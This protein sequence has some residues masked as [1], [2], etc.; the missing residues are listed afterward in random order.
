MG[1]HLSGQYVRPIQEPSPLRR[2]TLAGGGFG[3]TTSLRFQPADIRVARRRCHLSAPPAPPALPRPAGRRAGVNPLT[4]SPYQV[5]CCPAALIRARAAGRSEPCASSVS[6]CTVTSPRSRS[7][8]RGIRSALGAEW[9]PGRPNCAPGGQRRS[10]G[11]GPARLADRASPHHPGRR[12]GDRTGRPGHDRRHRS[13]PHP[14]AT[15]ELSRAKPTRPPVGHQSA[16]TGPISKQGRAHARGLLTVAALAAAI[17]RGPL[18]AFY[19]RIGARRRPQAGPSSG[20]SLGRARAASAPPRYRQRQSTR[21]LPSAPR[22]GSAPMPCAGRTT[23]P[24]SVTAQ[25]RPAASVP[26][27]SATR[28]VSGAEPAGTRPIPAK[29]PTARR[30]PAGSRG[31]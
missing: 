1:S 7:S 6:T 12:C 16:H 25:A 4:A 18:H 30:S 23:C 13:L 26:I 9:S 5:S 24:S 31:R 28:R 21:W 11:L 19:N 22:R 17:C 10:R 27:G 29:H 3:R 15:G 20:H 14:R 2:G 8:N